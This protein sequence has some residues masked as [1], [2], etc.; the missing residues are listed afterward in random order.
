MNVLESFGADAFALGLEIGDLDYND[1]VDGARGSG[2]VGEVFCA[3]IGVDWSGANRFTGE[4]QESVTGKDGG[5]FTEC[6]VA[7]GLAAAKVVVIER[8]EIVVDEGVGVNELDSA[9]GIERR[10]DVRRED[11]S[12]FE[13]EDGAYAFA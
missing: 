12:G 9:S 1:Y 4:S 5:G 13:A 3:E 7:S 10:S 2:D 11:A 6:F 8:G